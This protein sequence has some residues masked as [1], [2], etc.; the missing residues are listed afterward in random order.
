MLEL[1]KPKKEEL[2]YR[3][4]LLGDEATMAY[5]AK[6]GGTIAFSRQNWDSWYERWLLADEKERYYRYLYSWKE[7]SYVGEVCYRYD[8]LYGEYIVSIIV[9]AKHRGKGYGGTG[10][11]LL[12]EAARQ[13][14]IEKLCDD[15]AIGNPS[16]KLFL[17]EGFREVW[18]NEDCVM[19][20]RAL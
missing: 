4:A 9:E 10:L 20:E 16:V 8:A 6:W 12:I 1:Y 5:N 11:R 17:R 18:R 15:I 14:G 19:M 13:N 2:Y 7:Q 3:R